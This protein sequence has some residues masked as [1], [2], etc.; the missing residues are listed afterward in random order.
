MISVAPLVLGHIGTDEAG[1]EYCQEQL[2][3]EGLDNR[4]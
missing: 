1:N 2:A 4:K 3:S